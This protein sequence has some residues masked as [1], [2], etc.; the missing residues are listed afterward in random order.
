MKIKRTTYREFEEKFGGLNRLKI[1]RKDCNIVHYG[2]SIVPIR[3]RANI[4]YRPKKD[5]T[6]VGLTCLGYIDIFG[7]SADDLTIV[8]RFDGNVT[9]EDLIN[10]DFQYKDGLNAV[11]EELE[12]DWMRKLDSIK[13]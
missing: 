12:N 4:C 9:A 5:C 7:P 11:M 10:S 6:Y 3:Y 2:N 8:I 13:D 1:R